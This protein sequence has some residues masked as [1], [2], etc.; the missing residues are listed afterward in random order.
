MQWYVVQLP[1]Y[2]S[3]GHGEFYLGWFLSPAE[4]CSG[5]V[6]SV[7]CFKNENMF[8]LKKNNLIFIIT[9]INVLHYFTLQK[10]TVL[11]L[12]C[13]QS[14]CHLNVLHWFFLVKDTFEEQS[15]PTIIL[16]P[17]SA[18]LSRCTVWN[19]SCIESFTSIHVLILHT[20][21]MRDNI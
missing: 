1:H 20:V 6:Y 8:F 2:H 19:E 13:I 15:C 18:Y 10:T 4:E 21:S 17:F 7:H 16:L 5:M 11:V 14:F 9:G 12:P 3:C